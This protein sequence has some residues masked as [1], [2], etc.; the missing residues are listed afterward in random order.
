MYA[1]GWSVYIGGVCTCLNIYLCPFLYVHEQACHC[2]YLCIVKCRVRIV[3]CRGCIIKRRVCIVKC[4]VCIVKC[5]VCIVKCVSVHV[6]D[7]TNVYLHPHL[8]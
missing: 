5:R 6:T 1:C 8:M 7:K 3:K 4:R 2:A